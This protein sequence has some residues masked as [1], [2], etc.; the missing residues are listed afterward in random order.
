MVINESQISKRQ[1]NEDDKTDFVWI[2]VSA[3]NEDFSY[4]ASYELTYVLYNDGWQLEDYEQ[5]DSWFQAKTTCEKSIADAAIGKDYDSYTLVSSSD[6]E[7]NTMTFSYIADKVVSEYLSQQYQISVTCRFY[8]S[9]GW[10]VDTVSQSLSNETWN[11]CGNY[12]YEDERTELNIEVVDFD[13]DALTATLS[14]SFVLYEYPE[15]AGYRDRS[16]DPG[17]YASD[18]TITVDLT[19]GSYGDYRTFHYDPTYYRYL[20]YF[21]EYIEVT[22]AEI[23]FYGCQAGPFV[24]T[25]EGTGGYGDGIMVSLGLDFTG[26]SECYWLNKV[27]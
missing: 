27:N 20:Q 23:D 3:S 16:L 13:A 12:Y 15:N 8:V 2:D 17:V 18:G 5:I 26:W 19:E 4:T 7:G 14:Y 6:V 21:E 24:E 11:F 22:I 9:S 10:V 25:S 1:T